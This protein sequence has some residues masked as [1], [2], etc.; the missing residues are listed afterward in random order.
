LR[1]LTPS[2]EKDLADPEFAPG[3][4]TWRTAAQA[5]GNSSK[6][7]AIDLNLIENPNLQAIEEEGGHVSI[8]ARQ[9]DALIGWS[10]LRDLAD[11]ENPAIN[12]LAKSIQDAISG[13][14]YRSGGNRA[15]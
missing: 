10:E 11:V 12:S 1:N 13:V 14:V 9:W 3:L 7:Q 8:T 6:A 15:S 2:L 4:S 5:F